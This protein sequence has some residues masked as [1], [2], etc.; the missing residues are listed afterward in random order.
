MDD[1]DDID[2]RLADIERA[3]DA[4]ATDL[5]ALGFWSVVRPAK[6]DPDL[7]DRIADRAGRIDRRAFE[8]R[9]N[10]RAPVWVGN[11]LLLAGLVAGAV[12]VAVASRASSGLVA[13]VALVV[14]AGLWSVA[15]HDL[16][17][18]IVGAVVGIG[19]LAYF[20]G[21]PPPPRPGL[22]SRYETYLRASPAARA[23]MHASGAIATKVAP[24]AVLALYPSTRAPAWAAWVVLVIGIVQIATDV[25]FSTKS[26][27]WMRFSRE[28]SIAR[29]IP[30]ST[31]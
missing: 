25:A 4:G 18:W 16:A 12:A 3:V 11:A 14:A 23:W 30:R 9:V 2:R 28:M 27:D 19:F 7:A 31:T 10:P 21:G 22:K 5:S 26:S 29:S 13:G 17:H 1:F 20:L 8:A 24:F 15:V 6:G